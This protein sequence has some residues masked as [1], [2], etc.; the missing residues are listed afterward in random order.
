MNAVL[1]ST[2]DYFAPEIV[3]HLRENEPLRAKPCYDGFLRAVDLAVSITGI[4]F[5]SPLLGVLALLVKIQ[6]GGPVLFRQER[7]G[8]DGIPFAIFKYRTMIIDAETR[9]AK[10]QMTKNDSRVTR[11]G[12]FLRSY[13]LDELPQL[14]NVLRGDMSLVGPRP[15]LVFQKDYYE[16]WERPRLAVRPGI[17][18]LSQVSGGNRMN[19]DQRILVDVY[20]VRYRS[21]G[22]WAYILAKTVLAVFMKKG[23]TTADGCVKGWTRPVPDWYRDPHAS[24][25]QQ[26]IEPHA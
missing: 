25:R 17:T 6:D 21:F 26:E 24:P 15:A 22:M 23:I 13:H 9:G 4:I 16:A 1:K 10:W 20:Y 12:R 3:A 11:I 14:I 5:L 19:W 8:R 7:L 18:G 2:T